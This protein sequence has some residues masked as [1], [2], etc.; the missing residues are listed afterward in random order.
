MKVKELIEKL[1]K[2]PEDAIVLY[3]SGAGWHF[4]DKPVK[5]V[6]QKRAF[7]MQG[8]ACKG[9]YAILYDGEEKDY[10]P[11]TIIDAILIGE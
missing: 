2:F 7:V 8:A 11:K 4:Y 1:S 10:D 6:S 5:S 9:S 3:S